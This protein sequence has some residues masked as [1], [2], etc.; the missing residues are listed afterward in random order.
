MEMFG[1]MLNEEQENIAI[2]LTNTEKELN[3]TRNKIN[4]AYNQWRSIEGKYAHGTYQ[5][6]D[7]C[8]DMHYRGYS[9]TYAAGME[10]KEHQERL[11]FRSEVIAPLEEKEKF[12][13]DKIK[14]LKDSLCMKLYGFDF[15]TYL[16]KV[17]HAERLKK[18]IKRL[19]VKIADIKKELEELEREQGGNSP[20][21]F[22][23]R[24]SS[25]A[26]SGVQIYIFISNF[27]FRQNAQTG[28]SYF[29]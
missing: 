11:Q 2:E 27:L 8:G 29:S 6:E 4:S 26:T 1:K 25:S 23:S 13:K 22:F 5:D 3:E 14:Q 7:P 16:S 24:S 15:S 19:E 10:E 18:S 20:S 21:F 17:V 12:L 9:Y 28:Q